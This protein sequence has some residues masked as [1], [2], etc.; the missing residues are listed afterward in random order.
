MSKRLN[1]N[2]LNKQ[3]FIIVLMCNPMLR[4]DPIQLI[5]LRERI[6][7]YVQRIVLD[8][9]IPKINNAMEHR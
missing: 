3:H 9:L 1:V 4:S 5:R 6:T 8:K 7:F 2:L